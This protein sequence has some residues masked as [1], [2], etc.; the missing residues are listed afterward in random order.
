MKAGSG[1]RRTAQIATEPFLQTSSTTTAGPT[2]S[3]SAAPAAITDVVKRVAI[4]A[5]RAFARAARTESFKQAAAELHMS[6][7]ALSRQIQGLGEAIGPPWRADEKLACLGAWV[8]L[9]GPDAA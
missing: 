2:A 8:A 1:G 9:F 5:L 6:P 4:T 3:N 7:S